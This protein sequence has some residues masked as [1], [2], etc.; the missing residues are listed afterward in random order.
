MGVEYIYP[1]VL[2]EILEQQ[3]M[4]LEVH[5]EIIVGMVAPQWVTGPGNLALKELSKL[6]ETHER[7]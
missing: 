2:R 7:V 1:P 5:K 4:I 6:K 3:R